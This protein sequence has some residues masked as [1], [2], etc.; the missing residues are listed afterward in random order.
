MSNGSFMPKRLPPNDELDSDELLSRIVEFDEALASGQTLDLAGDP[1]LTELPDP[2]RKRLRRV[3]GCLEFLD[4]VR[5]VQRGMKGI[6]KAPDNG[7]K[8]LRDLPDA[9]E[10]R[11]KVGRFDVVRE[12]GR[13]GHGVVFLANDPILCRQVALK[14]PRPEFILSPGM[15]R[16]FVEEAQA[17]SALDHPNIIKVFD[18]G[19]DRAISFIAQE[20]C[21]GPSLAEWLRESTEVNPINAAMIVRDLAC[22]VEHAHQRGV[23]HRD[24]KPANVLLQPVEGAKE[25][26]T[27]KSWQELGLDS[28]RADGRSS[29]HFTPKLADFG[30]SKV[31]DEEADRTATA[32]G[33]AIGTVSYMSPE[34]AAGRT[35]QIGPQSDIYGLGAILYELLTGR[36]PFELDSRVSTLQRVIADE[37]PAPRSLRPSVPRD[38]EAICL[39]CLE[40]LQADRYAS[41]DAVAADLDRFLAGETVSVRPVARLVRSVR[42]LRRLPLSTQISLGAIALLVGL[43]ASMLLIWAAPRAGTTGQTGQSVNDEAEYLGGIERVSQGYFDAVANRGDTKTAVRELD[44]FLERHGPHP[45]RADYRGFEWHYL[46]RLCHPEKVAE[47]FPKLLELKGHRGEVYF[48]SFSPDGTLLATAGQDH[49]GRIWETATGKLRATLVGHTDD[50]NWISFHPQNWWNRRVLTASD[51][52]TIRI[53]DCDTGKPEGILS[54]GDKRAVAVEV[55]LV[56]YEHQPESHYEIAAGDDA[57][58]LWCWD[59]GTRR[60]LHSTP[61]H[62]G[63]VQALCSSRPGGWWITASS[64]GSAR[65][66]NGS[67]GT[68]F[69]AH[70]MDAGIYTV[71]CNSE[72]TLVAFGAGRPDRERGVAYQSDAIGRHL[73]AQIRIDDLLTGTQWF[74]L[75]APVTN[76]YD[77]VRFLPGRSLVIAAG[78]NC[79]PKKKEEPVLLWDLA[80]RESWKPMQ[81]DHP[82]CWC[83]SP[84]V[85]G[86]R[87]ATAGTDGIVRIWDSS[88][89]P[90]GTRLPGSFGQP[91]RH[92]GSVRYSPDGRELLVSYANLGLPGSGDSFI[93]WDVTG[94]RP[95]PLHAESTPADQAGSLAAGFSRDGRFIAVAVTH[96]SDKLVSSE[97]RILEADSLREIRHSSGYDGFVLSLV[98]SDDGRTVAVATQDQSRSNA[99]LYVWNG[100]QSKPKLFR[101]SNGA[102]FL[103]TVLSPDGKFLATNEDRVELYK[104]PSMR[105]AATLPI[106]LGNCGTIAFAPDGETL[107]AGGENGIIHLWDVSKG[108]KC[109]ELRS[110]GHAILSLAYSP[111]GTRL[112]AGLA[113]APRVDLWHLKSGKR[114]ATLAI[115]T[116]SQSVGDLVFS[117]DQRTLVAA[118]VGGTGCVFM[119]PLGPID[120]PAVSA[121]P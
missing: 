30:I 79:D 1:T 56:G 13:G 60:L 99:R 109:V 18:A 38:I 21:A 23:L 39:K 6:G 28:R 115:P 73:G 20:L 57:G 32:T 55:I 40:K 34:Q 89:L 29:L 36:P 88:V 76:T 52:K 114:L 3:L 90:G 91:N 41:A 44:A 120:L 117:P 33:A 48:A 5:R 86:T 87:L 100:D 97:I 50:V 70:V 22:G 71:S 85:D 35:S 105:L 68:S 37:P 51:D 2:T 82:A 17:S 84:S 61:A 15:G 65:E 26:G 77:S 118:G 45:N 43:V 102:H 11:L 69:R 25:Q 62:A 42:R 27:G 14:V 16:R 103:T 31:F 96:L 12:L 9:G 58:R 121:S 98:I 63:R 83:A 10:L 49:I 94:K 119:F 106:K 66:W 8:S 116:D 78:R 53:W 92:V 74:T 81:G 47:P 112:A 75:A 24:L 95:K 80:T 111:D 54:T 107:A 7:E 72:A 108:T 19:S 93:L 67:T 110:D 104:F 59:W 4:E 101:A 64:D 113:G 46:W